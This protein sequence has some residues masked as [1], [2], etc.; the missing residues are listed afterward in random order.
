MSLSYLV[1][2]SDMYGKSVPVAVC[3][4]LDE[5]DALCDSLAAALPKGELSFFSREAVVSADAPKE[6]VPSFVTVKS[7]ACALAWAD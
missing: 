3:K 6:E 4:S 2:K 7:L 5:A 1:S